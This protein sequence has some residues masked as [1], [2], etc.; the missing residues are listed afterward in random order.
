MSSELGNQE[1]PLE[2]VLAEID[3]ADKKIDHYLQGTERHIALAVSMITVVLTFAS[4]RARGIILFLPLG[5]HLLGHFGNRL[6]VELFALAGYK[7]YL[8]NRMQWDE[9]WERI[10]G[11]VI[12][13]S[14][15]EKT[16]K[17]IFPIV[18]TLLTTISLGYSWP[19][20]A[21][22]ATGISLFIGVAFTTTVSAVLLWTNG[23]RN[24]EA[25]Q[26]ALRLARRS[27][28]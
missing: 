24:F 27:R 17:L 22:T 26:S 20:Y 9:P 8:H 18:T 14:S 1:W 3:R 7:T 11:L 21:D 25:Y 12:H 23:K 4:E 15:S 2:W 10:V 6:G 16:A 19:A 28:Q 13:P 5:V